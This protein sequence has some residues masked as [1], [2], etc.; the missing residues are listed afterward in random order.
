MAAS[1]SVP[2]RKRAIITADD[3]GMSV[4]INEAIEEAYRKGL[5][6]TASLMV[7]GRAADDAVRRAKRLEGLRVGLHL[8]VIEGESMEHAPALT[9]SQG[10][11]GSDQLGLGV[12]YFFSPPHRRALEREILSQ[13]QA[14]ART[15][16]AL[17]HANAHKHM[18][19]HPTVGRY[20]I[21]H[22][23]NFGL[24]NV[25][26]P[27]EPTEVLGLRATRGEKTLALWTR[28][29]RQQIRQ[30]GMRTTDYC[31]GLR[32]SGAMTP[33]RLE[34]LL[35]NLPDGSSEIYFHPGTGHNSHMHSLMPTYRH[36]EEF[37]ALLAPTCRQAALKSGVELVSWPA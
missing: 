16:L 29:L 27:Y 21:A 30:A 24:R 26:V 34:S 23:R 6:S 33:E 8:V 20:M 1:R 3:F 22:G 35:A 18:H 10:W 4:E 7:A 14:F 32:W 25:R 28:L 19:L 2:A 31:F 36:E 17:D 12:K 5:L 37:A 13:F 11:L 9:D 15:G